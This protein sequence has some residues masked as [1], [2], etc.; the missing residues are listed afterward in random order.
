[1]NKIITRHK[2]SNA[3]EVESIPPFRNSR[4]HFESCW[5]IPSQAGRGSIK[6]FRFKSG[7]QLYINNY[8]TISSFR[9]KN[10][11]D[12]PVFGFRFCIS[13]RTKLSLNCLKKS[14]TIKSREN[15]FFYFPSTEGFHEDLAGTH[16]YK[17]LILIPPSSFLSLMEE[18]NLHASLRSKIPLHDGENMKAPFNV[19]GIITPAMHMILE[20]IIHCPYEGALRRIFTEAKA[21]ELIAC[22]LDQIQSNAGIQKKSS[23]LKR[24]DI[25]RLH[26]A[27]ELLSKNFPAPPNTM[28]LARMIGVSRSKL[29]NDFNRFYG[30]SPMEYVR[31]KRLEKARILVQDQDLSMTQIAYTLGYSSSSHFAKAFKEYFGTPPSHYRQKEIS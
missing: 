30:V 20:Q 2:H 13:G 12:A 10:N 6:Q 25:D 31:F 7:I 22:K 21:M 27:G 14:L 4:G 16:I 15:G 8:S 1:M 17:V 18:E 3:I 23:R 11:S 19:S 5:K 26:H 28:E 29:Y 9:I 24:S